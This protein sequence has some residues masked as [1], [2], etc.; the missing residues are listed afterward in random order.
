MINFV[1]NDG[2][3]ETTGVPIGTIN[4]YP[5]KYKFNWD[6]LRTML[7]MVIETLPTGKVFWFAP[8][9]QFSFDGVAAT[10]YDDCEAKI[11]AMF[12]KKGTGDGGGIGTLQQVTD[13]GATTDIPVKLSDL[14][15]T[16]DSGVRFN[17][18]SDGKH[19]ASGFGA[20]IGFDKVSGNCYVQCTAVSKVAGQTASF[21]T[22]P[23]LI[24]PDGSLNIGGSYGG[25]AYTAVPVLGI[26]VDID[27]NI[28]TYSL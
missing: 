15:I 7:Q 18:D 11:E 27:G 28:V 12:H 25:G 10:D 16:G 21:G 23:L 22:I 26:G 6:D 17:I 19:I 3:I 20:V 14:S 24:K 13:V 8:L 4:E 2:I 1:D 5:E 9:T